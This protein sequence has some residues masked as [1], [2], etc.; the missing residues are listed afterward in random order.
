[1]ELTFEQL[2]KQYQNK[3]AIDHLSL[4]LR[5]GIHGLLGPNGSGKTTF[6][7]MLCGLLQPSSGKIL[8][9]GQPI[10]A[11][12]EGYREILGYLPQDF[13]YYPDF[14][15]D[16]FMYYVS[17]LKGIAPHTAK[18]RVQHLLELVGLIDVSKNKLKRFSGGMKQR[19]GIAQA[20]LNDP[21]I[22]VLDEPTVGLD[23]KER[24][25]FRN[26]IAD[27][28]KNRIVLLSTHIVS[29]VAYLSDDILFMKNGSLIL[30]GTVKALTESIQGMI[31]TCSVPPHLVSGFVRKYDISHLH[32]H[33]DD[34][35]L[36]IISKERPT[37][38][39]QLQA[40]SL[41]D[42]YLYHF[43]E[44]SGGEAH[45]ANPTDL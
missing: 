25:R 39:A 28:S 33:G 7:R 24:M 22:L 32:H 2:T 9:N 23:P 37:A 21:K 38:D 14:R 16:E 44:H 12:G 30:R 3:T 1:M 34:V 29:D 10:H 20:M 8:F 36:R 5:P 18:E 31:W 26:L 35:E 45:C 41:E 13:G 42:L 15:A 40:G 6:M 11:L 43:G 4:T 19:L 17:A 27:L